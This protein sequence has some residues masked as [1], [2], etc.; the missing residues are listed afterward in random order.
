MEHSVT[1]ITIWI[2]QEEKKGAGQCTHDTKQSFRNLFFFK[3]DIFAVEKH[4]MSKK[5]G[6][7]TALL[8]RQHEEFQDGTDKKHSKYWDM[9]QNKEQSHL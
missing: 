3:N 1:E 2:K 8:V 4:K 9:N 7:P 5:L 6:G